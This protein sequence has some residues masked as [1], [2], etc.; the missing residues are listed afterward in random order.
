MAVERCAQVPC[1]QIARRTAPVRLHR[2]LTETSY[3]ATRSVVILFQYLYVILFQT[4]SVQLAF[5]QV[6]SQK[7]RGFKQFGFKNRIYRYL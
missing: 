7:Y 5:L 3:D 2:S 6:V 1:Y 4:G